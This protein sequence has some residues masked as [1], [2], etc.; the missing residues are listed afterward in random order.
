MEIR[1]LASP[2]SSI[3]GRFLGAAEPSDP[4]TVRRTLTAI[5]SGISIGLGYYLGTRIGF[6]LTPAGQPNSTFWP[7]NAILLGALLLTRRRIWWLLILAVLPAHMLAQAQVGV[8]L[9]TA[10]GWFVTNTGEALIGAFCIR[11]FMSTEGLFSSVRGVFVFLVFGGLF[12][13]LA[14]SFLDAGAVVITGWGHSYW[15]LGAERFWTNALAELTVVPCLLSWPSAVSWLRKASG[16]QW[17]EAVTLAAG[18]VLVTLLVFDFQW[19]SPVT[20]PAWIYVPLP[21]LSWATVRF[22]TGGLSF[23]VLGVTLTSI[24]YT[25][26]G[27]EPFPYAS[28]PQNILSLQILLCIVMVS[29][30]FLAAVMSEVRRTQESF[31]NV[32]GNLISAQE[33]ERQRIARDLHDDLG[34]RLALVQAD[35][36]ELTEEFGDSMKPRLG[37]LSSQLHDISTTVHEISHGLYPSHLEYL[38]LAS[39]VRRLCGEVQQGSNLSVGFVVGDLPAGLPY[40]TMLCLYRV[41]QEA[42]HNIVTHSQASNIQVELEAGD[43][44][45]L[46]RISDDGVGFDVDDAEVGLGLPSMR[47]RVRSVGGSIEITSSPK[48]GTRI[49]VRIPLA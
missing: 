14:T 25:M 19:L 5:L 46:L 32:S 7:P 26:H 10:V 8:P 49:E 34:Q 17:C 31:R 16:A 2:F 13:P 33:Q 42:L 44:G 6:A 11:K 28:M 29:L 4:A 23:S 35:V 24:W 43:K 36:N 22:G 37:Y 9:A 48:S 12:A 18:T 1:G 38:G 41:T 15:P 47:E 27:R 40:S 3:G 20:V 30:L 39:A 21:F 45:M